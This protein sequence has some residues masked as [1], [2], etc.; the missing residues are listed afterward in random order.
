MEVIVPDTSV[1]IEGTLSKQIEKK[2]IN[3]GKIIIHN[4][5]LGEL[6][7]QANEG[8][9]IGHVGLE[10]IKKLRE[11]VSID[12][13]GDRPRA[14]EIKYAK[15]GEIDNM[16]RQLAFEEGATLITSD[17]VQASVAEAKGISVIYVKPVM[18]KK[19]LK[20]EKY[21]DKTTMSVHIRENLGVNAKKG[22]P[23]DWKF[24]PVGKGK[25]KRE[26]IREMAM[27][28]VESAKG[29]RDGFIEIERAGSTIVQLGDYRIVM[30]QPA[31]SDGREI[32]AVRPVAKLDL[33]DYKLS[34]KLMKR[35][36][37]QADGMLIAG[38]PGHGKT[39][40]G[41]ALAEF[42][43]GENKIV[44]T[45]EA[46][47]DMLLSDNIT[48]YSIS[49]GSSEE[50]HDVLLLSRPDHTIYDEMR[51]TSDFMLFS[52]LRLAGIGMVG[53][54]HGTDPIDAVQRFLTRVELG[55]LPHIVDTVIFIKNGEVGKVLELSMTVKV[56]TGM[57][58]SDLARP[59][60]EVNDFETG[61]LEYEIYTYGEQTVVIPVEG[62]GEKSALSRY[63]EEGLIRTLSS[64]IKGDFN[65]EVIS[66]NRIR[67]FVPEHLIP[68]I[69]GSGG[70]NIEK[71]EQS[72]GIGIDV[73][74][75]KRQSRS[76]EIVF[77]VDI[78]K[79]IIFYLDKG[80]ANREVEIYSGSEMIVLTKA[81]KKWQIKLNKQS[82]VG[83]EVLKAIDA[84][85]IRLVVK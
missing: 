4:A 60:V 52:D 67:L 29:R 82:R 66:D 56:P 71:L 51:N 75:M 46:P 35:L 77:D 13:S 5:S 21:F 72:I 49:R 61:K 15:L 68:K 48:Q 9:T 65:V 2:E 26:D 79:N 7:H 33:K 59:V 78:R 28:I 69:I 73:Q 85:R 81:S 12:F 47:R 41:R 3:V 50:V 16:I 84:G 25:L 11:L 43:A 70:K 22:R 1:L 24:V 44:K 38:A 6:E 36:V 39:T 37:E 74:E 53:V 76:E 34:D 10:E 31:F 27:E 58:E 54:V 80:Y 63:A 64:Y 30:T 18:G 40:F 8:K 83:R 14:S 23:G 45:V 57:T 17:N 55:V 20:F 42:Y 19:K 62:E 32:T